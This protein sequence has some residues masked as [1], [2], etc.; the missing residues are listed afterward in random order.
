LL[1]GFRLLE[2]GAEPTENTAIISDLE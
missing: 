1:P 2:I